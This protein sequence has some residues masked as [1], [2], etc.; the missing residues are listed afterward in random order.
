[1]TRSELLNRLKKEG[2]PRDRYSLEGG[3]HDRRWCIERS[4]NRW[5]VY[6][7]ENGERTRVKNFLWEE[8][9]CQYFYDE[10]MAMLGREAK[11]M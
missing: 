8:V 11:T 3:L 5:Y 7:C 4:N 10:L 9:A 6:Y 1:M 2:V